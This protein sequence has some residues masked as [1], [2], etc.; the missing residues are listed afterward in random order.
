MIHLINEEWAL[1][2]LR[3]NNTY[4]INTS[5]LF[6]IVNDG[7]VSLKTID[8]EHIA[9]HPIW[10]SNLT[11]PRFNLADIRF[12]GIVVENMPN[13]YNKPYRLIDGKHRLAKMILEGKQRSEFY[14]FQ[15]EEILPFVELHPLNGHIRYTPG[16]KYSEDQ[17]FKI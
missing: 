12:P 10:K 4:C 16:D 1:P 5:K 7:A 17:I 3:D 15:Y 13:P 6:P 14:V 8:F 11:G 9:H 2:H